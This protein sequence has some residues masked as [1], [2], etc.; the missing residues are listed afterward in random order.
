DKSHGDFATNI[1]MQLARVAKQA[2]RQIAEKIVDELDQQQAQVNKV[3]IAGPGFINFFMDESYLHDVVQTVLQEDTQYGKTNV[4]SGKRIQVEFVSMNPT[5]EPHL[6]HA[7]GAVFGDVLSNLFA[8]AGYA[9][10]REYYINDAGNQID[11]VALS[12]EAGYLE[13]LGKDAKMPE[14][15]YQAAD[16]IAI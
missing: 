12:I 3:D 5:G 9:I 16:I 14:D 8:H 15:G 11:Q 13:A 6:G 1:A 2:P 10:E 4:G 7:R